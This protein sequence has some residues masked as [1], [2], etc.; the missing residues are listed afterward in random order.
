MRPINHPEYRYQP[1]SDERRSRASVRGKQMQRAREAA[2]GKP[3][4][5]QLMLHEERKL[6][7]QL[8]ELRS[9]IMVL[10]RYGLWK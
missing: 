6:E 4:I 8:S 1:W 3:T 5:I 9:A 7:N 2:R 10:K